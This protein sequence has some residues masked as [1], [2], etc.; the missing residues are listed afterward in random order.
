[1][2]KEVL[3]I[4]SAFANLLLGAIVYR[5][6]KKA[7]NRSFFI[8][9]INVFLWS[10]ALFFYT[11]PVLFSALAWI[12]I[13]Y[14]FSS[15]IVVTGFQFIAA[16]A[17][18][19]K[20]SVRRILKWYFVFI[21]PLIAILFFTDLWVKGVV[22]L[23]SGF[24]TLTGPVYLLFGIVI[25]IYIFLCFNP[26]YRKYKTSKG[27]EKLQF[28]YIFIG[29]L[30]FG[31][32][33]FAVDVFL[34]IF[35]GTSQYFWMSPLFSFFLVAFTS[36]AILRYH[37][38]EVRVIMTEILVVVM[39][40]I[41]LALTLF[42]E[43]TRL[44]MLTVFAF[45]LFC[46]FGY[47]LIKT[48]HAEIKRREEME[49]LTKRLRKAYKNIKELS[50]MKTEFLKVVGHQLRTPVSII[51]GLISMIE[52][53]SVPR[54]KRKKYT[55]ELYLTSE[56]LT[57]ILEDI[58]VAQRLVAEEYEVER[59]PCDITE[60]LEDVVEQ[61]EPMAA[62]K[63]LELAIGAS[64]EETS[65]VSIDEETVEKIVSRLV[66]NAILYTSAEKGEKKD[67]VISFDIQKEGRKRFLAISV[68]DSGIGLNEHDKKNLFKLFFRGKRAVYVRPNG[69]GLG[70]F[71]VKKLAEAHGG[72]IEAESKGRGKGSTFTLILPV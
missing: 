42:M 50:Q 51:R 38:F 5:K 45:I 39:G 52:E 13:T 67:I 7:L 58:L 55:K 31:I 25:A 54:E 21:V 33:A 18:V 28:R 19:D 72:K 9:A 37:L 62:K 22:S 71:I 1:M 57:T 14:L 64:E 12:K 49:K 60:L 69:S 53:G 20:V 11:H 68:R 26:L 23:P 61:F 17:D 65:K 43:T 47:L 48:T 30:L 63:R 27:I 6:E 8:F 59:A 70:L 34:P 16:F 3:I 35:A 15:I 2:E 4:F 40:L 32:P 24:H 46:I 56:R 66:D 44:K 10:I 29:L 41:L 36:L